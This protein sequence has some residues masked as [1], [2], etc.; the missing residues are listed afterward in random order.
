MDELDKHE[1][2]F[3]EISAKYEFRIKRGK[4]L[5]E[6]LKEKKEMLVKQANEQSGRIAFLSQQEQRSLRFKIVLMPALC[7]FVDFEHSRADD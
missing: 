5:I 1:H 2:L 3:N 4:K 7:I 6:E